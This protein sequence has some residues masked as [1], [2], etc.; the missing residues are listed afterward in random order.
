MERQSEPP[1][2]GVKRRS[3]SPKD[4]PAASRRRVTEAPVQPAPLAANANP[5]SVETVKYGEGPEK[6]AHS[7]PISD[8]PTSQTSPATSFN[9]TAS[10]DTRAAP[11]PQ[12]TN[13][14]SDPDAPAQQS[15]QTVKDPVPKQRTEGMSISE[16]RGDAAGAV[17]EQ[18]D[19]LHK[20]ADIMTCMIKD[21]RRM[22]KTIVKLD[23]RAAVIEKDLGSGSK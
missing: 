3:R 20:M 14:K 9:P 18:R 11:K 6:T 15:P 23:K 5:A 7:V 13:F 2:S 12:L 10:A 16:D 17:S 8:V 21:M 4:S 22:R 19:E 1:H